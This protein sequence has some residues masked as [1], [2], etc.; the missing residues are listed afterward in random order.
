M[1]TRELENTHNRIQGAEKGKEEEVDGSRED[2]W[3]EEHSGQPQL[4]VTPSQHFFPWREGT[5][6]GRCGQGKVGKRNVAGERRG[7]LKRQT[8]R[9]TASL[10]VFIVL[11]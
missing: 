5:I 6:E 1:G 2:A 9:V 3:E 10:D 4:F 7:A 11:G 8:H